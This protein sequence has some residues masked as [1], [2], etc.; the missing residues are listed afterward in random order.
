MHQRRA[1]RV[2]VIHSQNPDEGVY[3]RPNDLLL[4][5]TTSRISSG[6]FSN[7]VRELHRFQFIEML[8]N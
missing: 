5:R 3:L 4:W 1:L 6:Y 8:I 7:D 2:I